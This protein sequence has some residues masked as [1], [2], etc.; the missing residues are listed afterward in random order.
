[1]SKLRLARLMQGHLPNMEPK[2]ITEFGKLVR[3]YRANDPDPRNKAQW[4]EIIE[5][6]DK[7]QP[8]GD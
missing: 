1:M 6:F 8:H 2:A 5:D 7:A 4:D 3:R